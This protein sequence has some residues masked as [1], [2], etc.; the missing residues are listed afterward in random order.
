MM[1]SFGISVVSLSIVLSG[2][3]VHAQSADTVQADPATLTTP[4]ETAEGQENA[5]GPS[6]PVPPAPNVP[7]PEHTG[8]HALF[9]NVWH[10]FGALGS[11]SNLWIAG[12]GGAAA[13]AAHPLDS[14]TNAHLRGVGDFFQDG[15]ALGE[16]GI[17]IGSSLGTYV[18][19]R[20]T[21][22]PRASH[23]GMDLVRT[24]ILAETLT[25]GIKVAVQRQRPDG[26]N[27]AFPSGHTS[28][29]VATATVIQRHFGVVWSLPLYG[30]AA[31]VA[32]SRLHD[33]RH[34]LSDVVFGMAV[35]TVAGRTVTRHSQ[36]NYALMPAY[37]PGHGV[38]A[39]VTRVSEH[40]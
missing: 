24:Q 22:Y 26:S 11:S 27:F 8:I 14:T 29:T 21:H 7:T 1:R 35:G 30:T 5:A 16:T 3:A 9:R 36:S 2:A 38:A 15:K 28:I 33:N 20:L 34:W 18:I 10:D 12:M 32:A 17:Q 39:L 4:T 23:V 19:G 13:F 25:Q 31:Y 37:T 6:D 40:Q